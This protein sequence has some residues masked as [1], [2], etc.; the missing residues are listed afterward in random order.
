MR[1]ILKDHLKIRLKQRKIPQ[2]YPKKV[3]T[4]PFSIYRDNLTNH[5]IAIKE[6]AYYGKVRPMAVAYDII[7]KEIQIITIYPITN[8]EINNKVKNKRWTYEKK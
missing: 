5:L 2:S 7:F 4:N 6:L 8:K 3:I 1:I